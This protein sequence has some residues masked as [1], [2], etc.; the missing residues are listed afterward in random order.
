MMPILA[1]SQNGQ[2]KN[3]V[4]KTSHPPSQ[5]IYSQKSGIKNEK[6]VKSS[7]FFFYVFVFCDFQ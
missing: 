2:K 6:E 3:I 4:N 5:T 7:V 1:T